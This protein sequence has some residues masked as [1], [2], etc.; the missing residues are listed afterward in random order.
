MNIRILALCQYSVAGQR[1]LTGVSKQAIYQNVLNDL[2]EI[3]G[4][5]NYTYNRM[6]GE[7]W[8]FG[9]KWL[10]IGAHDEG[11]E[12]R[13]RGMTVGIAVCD[14]LVLMPRNFFMML[15][16]RMSPAG[17]RLYGSSNPDSPYHW[18]KEE[19]LDGDRFSHGLGKDVWWQTWSLNDNPNLSNE[20]K[21]FL[22]RSYVGVWHARYVEGLWVLAEGSILS[23]VLTPDVWY[24]DTTRPVGLLHRGGHMERFVSIDVGTV[25]SQVAGDFYDDGKTLFLENEAYFDSRK[26][27]F[28]KTN[29]QYATDLIEGDGN[30]W[31]GFP[32][33]QREWPGVIVDPSAASFKVELLSRG[34]FVMDANNEVADG[35]R[36]LA[37]MLGNK[38]FRIHERCIG[39]RGDLETYAWD[40]KAAARGEEKPIKDHDHGCDVCRYAIQTKISDWRIAA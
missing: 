10:V 19:I 15:L 29:A 30:G 14:E 35:I 32:K 37:A 11:S 27:G 39:I 9:T 4:D 20:Y 8:L 38:K 7:L 22:K 25:N 33:D 36:R 6:T 5:S 34:V 1:I 3:V 16:S 2:F 24:N 28:Q 31:P 26:A 12:K 21:E 17:S 18:L 13:I 40:E 23:G